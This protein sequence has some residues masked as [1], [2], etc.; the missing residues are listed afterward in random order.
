MITVVR[1]SMVMYPAGFVVQY[2]PGNNENHCR[3]QQPGAVMKEKLFHH[4][5]NE[6]CK[7]KKKGYKAMMVS[8]IT[9]IQGV[10][11]NSESKQDHTY[12]K[13][14]MM[15]YVDTKKRKAA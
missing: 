14:G 4:Q 3:N 5:K 2:M 6:P 8:F 12:F 1:M 11:A 15:N 9:M 7:K 10:G 13:T